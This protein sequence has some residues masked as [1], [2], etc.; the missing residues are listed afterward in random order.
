MLRVGRSQKGITP[1]QPFLM[2]GSFVEFESRD[3][4]DPLMAS[5]LVATGERRWTRTH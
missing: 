4:L 1:G 5:C 2:G 3:V